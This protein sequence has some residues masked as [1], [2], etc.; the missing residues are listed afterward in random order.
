GGRAPAG[1]TF[2]AKNADKTKEGFTAESAESAERK[3][4]AQRRAVPRIL[5]FVFSALSALSAV[6]CVAAPDDAA[7]PLAP[8]CRAWLRAEY[9]LWKLPG[10]TAPV[11]VGTIPSADAE[12]SRAL[13]PGTIRPLLGG[14]DAR[15]GFD[16]QS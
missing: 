3:T 16:P 5:A 12:V 11:L 15:V 9:L 13:P 14:P 6:K 8:D 1:F 10:E 4:M 2:C 7:D